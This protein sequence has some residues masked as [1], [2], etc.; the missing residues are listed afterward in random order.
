FPSKENFHLKKVLQQYLF[1]YRFPSKESEYL[2]WYTF[3]F[4]NALSPEHEKKKSLVCSLH[5]EASCFVLDKSRKLLK[6]NSCPSIIV[7]TLTDT[8]K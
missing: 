1:Y 4:E 2:K 3:L 7:N 5:F 8:Q 6:K